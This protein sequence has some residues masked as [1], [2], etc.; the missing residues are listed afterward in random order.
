MMAGDAN[1]DELLYT[2]NEASS[3]LPFPT[4]TK[5]LYAAFVSVVIMV[6][7]N[8]LIGLTVSDIQVWTDLC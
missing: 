7:F 4:S 3:E 8:L 5:M 2:Y 1:F 6:L